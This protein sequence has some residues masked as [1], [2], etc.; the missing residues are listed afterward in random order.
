MSDDKK[1]AYFDP[2]VRFMK[3]SHNCGPHDGDYDSDDMQ[4]AYHTGWVDRE[5]ELEAVKADCVKMLSEQDYEYNRKTNDLIDRHAKQIA[6]LRATLAHER[7]A[8]AHTTVYRQLLTDE[9]AVALC[10]EAGANLEQLAGIARELAAHTDRL[11][12]E[13]RIIAMADTYSWDDPTE[14]EAWAK[15][16]ARAAISEEP[17]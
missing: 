12:E 6:E 10:G 5:P 2:F 4:G 9:L 1:P 16:R 11:T 17:K 15:N 14:Y 7:S 8:F 13:L 3:D